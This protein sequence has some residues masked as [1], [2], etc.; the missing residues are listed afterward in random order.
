MSI[1]LIEKTITH[2]GVYLASDDNADG[3]SQVTVEVEPYT[4]YGEFTENGVYYPPEYGY[5]FYEIYVDVPPA[6]LNLRLGTSVDDIAKATCPETK[7]VDIDLDKWIYVGYINAWQVEVRIGY[8]DD[9]SGDW[10][11]GG[12][13]MLGRGTRPSYCNITKIEMNTQ[14]RGLTVTADF[15]TIGNYGYVTP[16]QRAILPADHYNPDTGRYEY[17][18]NEHI[19]ATFETDLPDNYDSETGE[20]SY[21][22]DPTHHMQLKK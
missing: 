12:A 1:T 19:I 7:V 18:P 16:Y 6:P 9:E 5:G 3:Y 11:T 2:N 21:F 8:T 4:E 10:A 14:T 22:G 13:V 20:Y 15:G 17:A